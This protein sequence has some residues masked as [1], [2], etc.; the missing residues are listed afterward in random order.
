LL[1]DGDP[2][3]FR[4]PDIEHHNV[5]GLGITQVI[6]FLA[7]RRTVDGIASVGQGPNQLSIQVSII[8]DDKDAHWLDLRKTSFKY[9]A[10]GANCNR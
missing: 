1:E 2:V 8:L 5:V 4:Q 9:R 6:A 10:L 7:I 3:H